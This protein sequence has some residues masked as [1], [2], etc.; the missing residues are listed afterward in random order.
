M[1]RIQV[2]SRS[3]ERNPISNDKT[4]RKDVGA[5]GITDVAFSHRLAI[6][7]SDLRLSVLEYEGAAPAITDIEDARAHDDGGDE[8]NGEKDADGAHGAL[9]GG[10]KHYG[11]QCRRV[12]MSR[13]MQVVNHDVVAR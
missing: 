10:H 2:G 5:L 4:C 9:V 3:G 12:R 8:V 1:H 13:M 11:L 7:V 6:R